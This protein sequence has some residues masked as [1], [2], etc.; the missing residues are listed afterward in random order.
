M[1]IATDPGQ[2]IPPSTLQNRLRDARE[3][4]G[5][6]Q[7]DLAA[8]LGIGRSTVSNYERGIT[9]PGKLV[10]NAWA[11]ACDVDVEWLKTGTE[12]ATDPRG[13]NDPAGGTLRKITFW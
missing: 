4:R 5:L 10:V 1:T 9:P 12:A 13:G 2:R 11:V 8:E 3:W 7:A 6:E